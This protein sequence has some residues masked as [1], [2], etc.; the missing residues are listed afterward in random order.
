MICD[1]QITRYTKR[2]TVPDELMRNW[3]TV[4][5]QTAAM[6]TQPYPTRVEAMTPR[7]GTPLRLTPAIQRGASSLAAST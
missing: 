6:T 4:S 3:K 2:N 5:G 1:R 7:T